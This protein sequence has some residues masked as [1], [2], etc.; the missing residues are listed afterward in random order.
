MRSTV[1][2][3]GVAAALL[4]TVV[5]PSEYG[6][7]PTGAGRALGLAEM[8]EIKTQLAEEAEADR[9]KDQAAPTP[10]APAAP[11][12]RSS[13]LGSIF[14]QL[15]IGSAQAQ[16]PAAKSQEIAVTLQPGEGTEVKADMKQGAKLTYSWK[17]EGGTVNHD[18]H[19][20]GPG[21]KEV[22]YSKGRGV[23]G[24]EGEITAGFDGG[25]G[26]FW[27]NRG[28]APVTVKLTASGDFGS[29]K[30]AK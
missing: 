8:G 1:I 24:D 30:Q 22:S 12:Q 20:A 11:E 25:H 4:V 16:T 17:V 27:R 28:S 29:L 2:A 9:A 15:V 21:G 23:P 10:A 3:A 26:W 5:L 7:D 6:I 14:A 19:G 18:T 13:L